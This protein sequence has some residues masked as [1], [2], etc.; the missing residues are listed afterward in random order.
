MSTSKVPLKTSRIT[1]QATVLAPGSSNGG[2]DDAAITCTALRADDIG[3]PHRPNTRSKSALYHPSRLAFKLTH[4]R[5]ELSQIVKSLSVHR[6]SRAHPSSHAMKC[7][8]RCD[9]IR[10]VCESHPDRPWLGPSECGCGAAARPARPAMMQTR[11][12]CPRCQRASCPTNYSTNGGMVS[13]TTSFASR[14]VTQR[15]VS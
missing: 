7:C 14:T 1:G 15:P 6:T 8:F 11:T 2:Y 9:N 12:M 13:I 3:F 4:Y 10:W 5:K